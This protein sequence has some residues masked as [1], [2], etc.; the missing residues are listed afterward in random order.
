MCRLLG[1]S[2]AATTTF[3]EVVGENFDQ[4]VCLAKD[5]CDG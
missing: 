3:N 4:F 1:Y 5:H 2:A